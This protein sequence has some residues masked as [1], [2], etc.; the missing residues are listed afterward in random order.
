MKMKRWA[1]Y[2][3]VFWAGLWLG[4]IYG[5]IGMNSFNKRANPE[6]KC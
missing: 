4:T 5:A 2:A 1:T 6:P 3:L